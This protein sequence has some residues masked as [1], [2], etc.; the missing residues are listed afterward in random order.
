MLPAMHSS[1][2]IHTPPTS[3]TTREAAVAMIRTERA[4]PWLRGQF[5][6]GQDLSARPRQ[7]QGDLE[8]ERPV[9]GDEQAFAREHAIAAQQR[10]RRARGHDAGKSPTGDRQ[11]ALVGAGGDNQALR[12]A[13]PADLAVEKHEIQGLEGAPDLGAL[14]QG[15]ARR[16]DPRDQ[17]PAPGEL[18]IVGKRLGKTGHVQPLLIELAASHRPLVDHQ[19]FRPGLCGGRSGIQP[20]GAAA[21][22]EN[23]RLEDIGRLV[24]CGHAGDLPRGGKKLLAAHVDRFFQL[25]HAGPLAR[26]AVDLHQAFLADAH[27]AE[28]A[29]VHALAGNPK[30]PFAH[31]GQGGGQGL[32]APAADGPALELEFDDVGAWPQLDG[33]I[34]RAH[35][36]ASNSSRAGSSRRHFRRAQVTP[37]LPVPTMAT[38]SFLAE[39]AVMWNPK[40]M[41]APFHRPARSLSTKPIR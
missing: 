10:L 27:A 21:Q 28:E 15:D 38:V 36:G 2:P 33:A 40:R 4:N 1:A 39:V 7:F 29:A 26:P 32:P 25:G 41:R 30:F 35:D 20:A 34:G 5:G 14:H 12:P 8:I 6:H 9:A 22:H 37:M 23:I 19:D 24:C 3:V 13:E 11:A 16:L 31:G 18:G 17:R